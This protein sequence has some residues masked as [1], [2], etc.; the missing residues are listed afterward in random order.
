MARDTL[1][2]RYQSTLTYLYSFREAFDR[3]EDRSPG[4]IG[5][6]WPPLTPE[7]KQN[8]EEFRA[9][10]RDAIACLEASHRIDDARPKG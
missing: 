2:P 5:T 4:A 6:A 7:Q 10:L 8:L 1:P 9:H 3:P